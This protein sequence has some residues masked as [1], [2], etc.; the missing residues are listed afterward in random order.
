M[1]TI[2]RIAATSVLFLA[3]CTQTRLERALAMAGDNRAELEK[4]LTHYTQNPAD[5]LKLR[6]AEF[7]I[8]NMPWHYSYGGEWYDDYVRRVDSMHHDLPIELRLVLYTLP[9][10][11]PSLAG[12]LE[13]RPDVE[14][15]T[16]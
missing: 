15:I 12:K 7:L 14:N 1:K 4:V 11:Y 9:E 6:A 8:E 3:S 2:L 10:K 5:E 16:A 13:I